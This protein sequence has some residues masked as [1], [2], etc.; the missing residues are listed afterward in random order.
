M[1][2]DEP[3]RV[4]LVDD[5]PLMRRTG[6][7]VLRRRLA[8]EVVV[9]DGGFDAVSRL[10]IGERYDLIVAD[11]E[12]PGMDGFELIERIRQIDPEAAI[13]VWSGSD[14]L[15]LAEQ[16]AVSFAV[17]KT[18]PIGELIDAIAFALAERG[19]QM[20]QIRR[21]GFRVRRDTPS[22]EGNGNGR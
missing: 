9:A 8:V 1:T 13:G 19:A 17:R 5:D 11:L 20:H 3:I 6:S 22:H 18:R 15:P 14:R 4:L 10:R 12:M 21:S 16:R 7:R 2:R